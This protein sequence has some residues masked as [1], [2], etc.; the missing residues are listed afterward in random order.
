MKSTSTI[1]LAIAFAAMIPFQLGA[2]QDA[3]ATRGLDTT[4]GVEALQAGETL[5]VD[6]GA[7]A[8]DAERVRAELAEFLGNERVRGIAEGRGFDVEEV[9][10]GSM[11]LSDRAVSGLS[12]AL[13]KA[14]AALEQGRTITI[15]VYTV[16]IFLLILILI[17]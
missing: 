11:G 14:N 6:A 5:Q 10:N 4:T 9:E 13:D 1:L 12:W 16:I 7:D 8:T 15:S 2:Q 17:T 3:E